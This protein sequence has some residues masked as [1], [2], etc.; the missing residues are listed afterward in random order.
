MRLL[1]ALA[2]AGLSG[3]AASREV[4]VADK[5]SASSAPI[6]LLLGDVPLVY[7]RDL[8]AR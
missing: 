4:S 5:A 2:I 6:E 1:A 3:C 7:P 8:S